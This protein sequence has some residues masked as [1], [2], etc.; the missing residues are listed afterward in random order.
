ML[1][2]QNI[3]V[4][5]HRTSIRLEPEFWTAFADIAQRENQSIDQLCSEIDRHAGELSRT[6]AV[7]IFIT[8][9]MVQL[10]KRSAIEVQLGQNVGHHSHDMIG[11]V[12]YS[13]GLAQPA[14]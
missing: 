12:G 8:M 11:G 7:R 14:S 5:G 10:S 2:N 1:V 9:Y 4:N 6:A 13:T 3:T